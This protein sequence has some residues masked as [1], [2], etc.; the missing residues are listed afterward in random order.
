V[1]EICFKGGVAFFPCKAEAVACKKKFFKWGNLFPAFE[2]SCIR[3]GAFEEVKVSQRVFA[4]AERTHDLQKNGGGSL[5]GKHFPKGKG[6]LHWE[7]GR[8]K[9]MAV[10]TRIGTH[11]GIRGLKEK[12]NEKERGP[13]AIGDS[14]RLWRVRKKKKEG[15]PSDY[16]GA[17]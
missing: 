13:E 15:M 5:R 1:Q 17:E 16:D 11:Q 10:Q 9:G 3:G 4:I 6:R 2:G 12:C 14:A 7:N 8:S